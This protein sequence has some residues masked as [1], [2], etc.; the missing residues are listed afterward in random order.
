M[1]Y[2]NGARWRDNMEDNY[3]YS[4]DAY[5]PKVNLTEKEMDMIDELGRTKKNLYNLIMAEECPI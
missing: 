2:K 1:K 4:M 5:W 3:N